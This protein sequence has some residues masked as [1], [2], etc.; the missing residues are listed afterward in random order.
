MLVQEFNQK[1]ES[2]KR[3]IKKSLKI[4]ERSRVP[5]TV[6]DVMFNLGNIED[7]IIFSKFVEDSNTRIFSSEYD[8]ALLLDLLGHGFD[9]KSKRGFMVELNQTKPRLTKALTDRKMIQESVV[10]HRLRGL[11]EGKDLKR[12]FEDMLNDLQK[13]LRTALKQTRKGDFEDYL[14]IENFV[15]YGEFTSYF[16]Q[17]SK[18]P[19]KKSYIL[20][21]IMDGFANDMSDF[22]K[23]SVLSGYHRGLK[24]IEKEMPRK[25][26]SEVERFDIIISAIKK[27]LEQELTK[28]ER[29]G[30][31]DL[32]KI[33]PTSELF[34]AF[35]MIHM[36]LTAAAEE[37][38]APEF[39]QFMT[40]RMIMDGVIDNFKTKNKIEFIKWYDEVMD[41]G[42]AQINQTPSRA[43]SLDDDFGGRGMFEGFDSD[44]SKSKT[45]A[46]MSYA[47]YLIGLA[48]K[49]GNTIPVVGHSWMDGSMYEETYEKIVYNQNKS[50]LV[51]RTEESVEYIGYYNFKSVAIPTLQ[52]IVRAYQV[53][54]GNNGI[55]FDKI[56]K[57]LL[58]RMKRVQLTTSEKRVQLTES[59]E[60][61]TGLYD[62]LFDNF[63][64]EA[65]RLHITLPRVKGKQS[66][67]GATINNMGLDNG[68]PF[69]EGKGELKLHEIKPSFITY[70]DI[71]DVTDYYW[72]K[73]FFIMEFGKESI[74]RLART[75][76]T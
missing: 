23:M 17:Y 3:A 11:F 32:G 53:A 27:V 8:T 52:D 68:T 20:E 60:Y 5:R 46:L 26:L 35:Q 31:D 73:H 70:V 34:V 6:I 36:N 76:A 62:I 13:G 48:I 9:D 59:M 2:L 58:E 12:E 15:A 42:M 50:T 64:G 65:V 49:D 75:M 25:P 10:C 1:Y 39:D 29:K 30:L 72:D 56:S 24:T 7:V 55:R 14:E 4:V 33:W 38:N 37:M 61:R 18:K 67:I 44:H 63:L 16:N 71:Y 47:N 22:D 74:V 19:H 40:G 41:E 21:L 57:K 66:Y 28:A 69:I 43:P 51:I 45:L 54:L